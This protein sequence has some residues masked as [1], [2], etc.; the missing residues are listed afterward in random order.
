MLRGGIDKPMRSAAP[1][2]TAQED[3]AGQEAAQAA[4]TADAAGSA[5]PASAAGDGAA[6]AEPEAAPAAPAAPAAADENSDFDDDGAS[7]IGP[8]S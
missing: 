1:T 4:L 5:E 7:H 2:R 8:L 3:L 6:P